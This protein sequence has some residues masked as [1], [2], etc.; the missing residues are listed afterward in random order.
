MEWD[1][2]QKSGFSEVVRK[3]ELKGMDV[4]QLRSVSHIRFL[5]TDPYSQGQIRHRYP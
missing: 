2:L 4:K 3:I 1:I 5:V